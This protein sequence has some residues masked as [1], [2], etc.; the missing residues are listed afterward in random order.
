[1]PAVQ[2]EAAESGQLAQISTVTA[3]TLERQPTDAEGCQPC[4]LGLAE[5]PTFSQHDYDLL[6]MVPTSEPSKQPCQQ[7][8]PTAVGSST[9]AMAKVRTPVP[10]NASMTMRARTR[11]GPALASYLSA[12]ARSRT[13]MVSPVLYGVRSA[14]ACSMYTAARSLSPTT[15][16]HDSHTDTQGSTSGSDAAASC[17]AALASSEPPMFE[18]L[19]KPPRQ[20]AGQT[21][22]ALRYTPLL[23][24][25]VS[26]A[27][28]VGMCVTSSSISC[29]CCLQDVWQPHSAMQACAQ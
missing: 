16:R 23:S 29:I 11:K 21:T 28:S 25:V 1:M 17:S 18:D 19:V 7:P 15:E 3:E 5:A 24:Y 20:A 14:T 8:L 6:A 26:S 2:L 22:P 12:H 27:K 4:S 9:A 13:N 10:R